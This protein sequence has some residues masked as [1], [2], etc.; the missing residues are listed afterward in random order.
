MREGIDYFWI[1]TRKVNREVS[2]VRQNRKIV[3]D[4]DE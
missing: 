1:P 4:G 3:K 2:K